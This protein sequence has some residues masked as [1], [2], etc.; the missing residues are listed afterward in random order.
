[1]GHSTDSGRAET[2]ELIAHDFESLAQFGNI[3]VVRSIDRTLRAP[4]VARTKG[5]VYATIDNT[6]DIRYITFYNSE[7]E[8]KK[9]IDVKGRSHNGVGVP[10]THEGLDHDAGFHE[11]SNKEQEVIDKALSSWARTRKKLGI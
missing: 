1:M 7:G 8:K 6:G 2:R 5:R 3:K 10:H 11:P 9:Q 4:R